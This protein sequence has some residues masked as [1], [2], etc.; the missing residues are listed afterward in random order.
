MHNTD[1]RAAI[2]WRLRARHTTATCVLQPLAVG[3]LLTLLQDDDV[4][5]REAFPDAHLAEARARALRARLQGKGWHAVP[6][7]NAGCGRRRA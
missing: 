5:F 7:A 3:A 1:D 6:I 4:V 2:L